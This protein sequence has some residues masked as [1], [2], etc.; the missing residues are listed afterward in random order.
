MHHATSS[1][2]Q[3]L[4]PLDVGPLQPIGNCPMDCTRGQFVPRPFFRQLA[5]CFSSIRFLLAS[6]S[7]RP[8]DLLSIRTLGQLRFL[9]GIDTSTRSSLP[10]I[11]TLVSSL[12]WQEWH[13][14][15]KVSSGSIS[16]VCARRCAS[17]CD[18]SDEVRP[19]PGSLFGSPTTHSLSNVGSKG[20]ARPIERKSGWTYPLD[21]GNEEEKDPPFR[22]RVDRGVQRTRWNRR[23]AETPRFREVWSQETTVKDVVRRSVRETTFEIRSCDQRSLRSDPAVTWGVYFPGVSTIA[24]LVEDD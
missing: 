8:M 13:D 24:P 19:R 11:R 5:R 16:M 18:V 21:Q 2:C 7:M 9:P 10:R 22:A 23:H 17:T 14:A 1:L 12:V 20:N 15:S 6:F 3:G 4:E